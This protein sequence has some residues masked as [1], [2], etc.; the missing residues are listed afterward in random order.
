MFNDVPWVWVQLSMRASGEARKPM[1]ESKPQKLAVTYA[2]CNCLADMVALAM[3][4]KSYSQMIT[5]TLAY[6]SI[7]ARCTA[8]P[9]SGSD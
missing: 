2:P 1:P 9:R 4:L 8:Y 3:G 6:P 5:P 7:E